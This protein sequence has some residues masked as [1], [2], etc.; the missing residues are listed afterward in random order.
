MTSSWL[1]ELVRRNTLL[2]IGTIS[3]EGSLKD[4]LTFNLSDPNWWSRPFSV[5]RRICLLAA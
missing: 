5:A 4:K 1:E 2:P 3:N